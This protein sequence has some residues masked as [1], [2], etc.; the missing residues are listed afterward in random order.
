MLKGQGS[1]YIFLVLGG[2]IALSYLISGG[3][4][5]HINRDDEFDQAVSEV[6]FPP[7]NDTASLQLKSL[8][9]DPE[10]VYTVSPETEVN[11]G[12]RSNTVPL[13]GQE[14]PQDPLEIKSVLCQEYRVCP[15]EST[16]D[17]PN[18]P[19]T[20]KQLTALW[21]VVQRIY[22]S[23]TYKALV[24]DEASGGIEIQRSGYVTPG[25]SG[26]IY[27]RHVGQRNSNY[28]TIPNSNLLLITDNA[29]GNNS[30]GL[31]E[32]LFAHEIGHISQSWQNAPD[33]LEGCREPVSTYGRDASSNIENFAEAVSYY[34]T[35]GE[36][37]RSRYLGPSNNLKIDYPCVY[38][39]LKS[40][41]FG[42]VEY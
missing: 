34:M 30:Q 4:L 37:S 27:G 26:T 10:S 5:P 40:N 33:R 29:N 39:F 32:A 25:G 35:D 22:A 17:P 20:L 31:Y 21:N 24:V 13:P 3:I 7:S 9:F 8:G 18:S 11:T 36:A 42:G 14:M 23:P 41:L 2:V 16:Y 19:W 1:V 12:A 38:N 6:S 15:K 28:R